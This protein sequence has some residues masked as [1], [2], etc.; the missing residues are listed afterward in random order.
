VPDPKPEDYLR[1]LGVQVAN[2]KV[3]EGGQPV[4]FVLD[5]VDAE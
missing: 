1:T 4:P 3:Q 5:E 2:I